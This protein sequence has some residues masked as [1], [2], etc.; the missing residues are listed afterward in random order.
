MRSSSTS[1]RRIVGWS[2]CFEKARWIEKHNP[3]PMWN[4]GCEGVLQRGIVR[5]DV[6][7]EIRPLPSMP[8]VL[9]HTLLSARDLLVTAGPF[10][11]IALG[12]LTLAY[13]ALDPNPPRKVVLATGAEQGAYAEFGKRYA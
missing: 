9:R 2:D 11:L 5:V 3:V 1:S 7:A 13:F 4:R 10:L 6:H 8:K 12:L